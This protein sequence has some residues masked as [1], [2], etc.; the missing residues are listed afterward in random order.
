MK[1]N[2]RGKYHCPASDRPFHN[3]RA[4]K[5]VDHCF[6]TTLSSSIDGN[7]GSETVKKAGRGTIGLTTASVSAQ[8]RKTFPAECL[9]T[10]VGINL[11]SSL[12]LHCDVEISR[13]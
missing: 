12:I 1:R 9:K 4:S 10:L 2:G 7:E 5:S 3:L 8:A 11:G 13:T 6:R